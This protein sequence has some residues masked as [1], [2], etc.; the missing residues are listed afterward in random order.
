MKKSAPVFGVK[1]ARCGKRMARAAWDKH[2]AKCAP[3]VQPG[4]S[5]ADYKKRITAPKGCGG[6]GTCSKCIA[7]QGRPFF[8]AVD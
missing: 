6:C 5:W 8:S 7:S 1:C 3:P 2:A 4:E